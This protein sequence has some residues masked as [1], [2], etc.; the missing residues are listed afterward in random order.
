M[1]W[2]FSGA[3]LCFAVVE[4]AQRPAAYAALWFSSGDLLLLGTAW[5]AAMT[6]L[7]PA[8]ATIT[9]W[10]YLRGTGL[11][12]WQWPAAWF[13]TAAA[14]IG[15]EVMLVWSITGDVRLPAGNGLA[16]GR[17]PAPLELLAAFLAAGAAM[18]AILVIATRTCSSR[19]ALRVR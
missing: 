1:L 4:D 6:S 9:G 5:L 3:F 7:G 18:I 16:G 17:G 2:A 15:V 14:G 19:L 13:A 12:G 8:I 10:R 11:A